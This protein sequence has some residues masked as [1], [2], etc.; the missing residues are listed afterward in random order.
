[1]DGKPILLK[2]DVWD[3]ASLIARHINSGIIDIISP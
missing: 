2:Y 1:M 3:A